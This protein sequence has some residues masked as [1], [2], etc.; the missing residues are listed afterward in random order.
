MN[1]NIGVN[2]NKGSPKY[3]DNKPVA[4]IYI[5]VNAR[6][7]SSALRDL[8][9]ARE[10]IQELLVGYMDVVQDGGSKG[11]LFHDIASSCKGDHRPRDSTSNAVR[12]KD[13]RGFDNFMSVVELPSHAGAF[14]AKYILQKYVLVQIRSLN[15]FIKIC[16][17]DFGVPL[18]YCDAHVLVTGLH[19]Q[20]VDGAVEIVNDV[21]RRHMGD[22]S[23]TF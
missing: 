4:P 9:N 18:K 6:S 20:G 8:D 22:C 2:Y 1:C 5:T 3:R 10:G 13:P 16:G 23:C 19:W 17:N 21:I 14:H 11:R 12:S 15:C 7:H